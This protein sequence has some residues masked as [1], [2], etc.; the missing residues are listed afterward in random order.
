MFSLNSLLVPPKSW[1]KLKIIDQDNYGRFVGE[2]YKGNDL[3]NLKMVKEGKAYVYDKYIDNCDRKEK[4]VKAQEKAK[5]KQKGIWK[6]NVQ[7]PWL[8]RMFE[9]K[10]KSK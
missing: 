1:V 5:K 2:I 3:I 10:N 7:K 6:E 9:R 8:F 4:Y